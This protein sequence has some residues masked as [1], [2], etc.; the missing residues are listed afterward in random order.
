[1]FLYFWFC[2][3]FLHFPFWIFF[4]YFLFILVFR[5]LCNIQ[6]H[7]KFIVILLPSSER[8]IVF[9]LDHS[10]GVLMTCVHLPHTFGVHF[11]YTNFFTVCKFLRCSN[12]YALDKWCIDMISRIYRLVSKIVIDNWLFFVFLNWSDKKN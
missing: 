12:E 4:C 7:S 6:D 10:L 11:K 2:N 1:M 9:N 8:K 3:L 5:I